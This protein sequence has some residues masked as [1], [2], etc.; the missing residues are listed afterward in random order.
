MSP[1][2]SSPRHLLPFSHAQSAV[3][4]IPGLLTFSACLVV[5]L[6]TL[7]PDLSWLYF[8]ADGGELITAAVTLGIPHPPG[9]PTYV[10]MGKLI[11]LLP[12]GAVAYRFNLLSAL[13]IAFAAGVTT[14]AAL[15]LVEDTHHG[16][17]AAIAAGLSFGFAPLVWSQALIAEVYG[18]NLAFLALFLWALLGKRP[19]LLTGIFLGLSMT[20]HLTSLLMLPLAFGL[21]PRTR[22]PRLISGI[23][24]G[25]TPFLLLPLFAKGNSPV[26][27]G[28]PNTLSGWW[29]LVSA[30]IYRPNLSIPGL[31]ELLTRLADWSMMAAQQF[32]WIGW[33]SVILAIF[34]AGHIENTRNKRQTP[35]ILGLLLGTAVLFA[36]LS[37]LYATEDAWLY[38]LPGILLTALVLARGLAQIGAWAF[39]LP[40]LLLLFNFSTFNTPKLPLA[41]QV[42]A[43]ALQP[44]PQNAIV[45]TP[46]DRSIFTLWYAQHIT[47]LRPDLT[48][49]DSNL[50]AFD[51]YR[52]RLQ[53]QYPTLQG[54]EIDD[55][56]QFQTANAQKRPFCRLSLLSPKTIL[57]TEDQP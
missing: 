4:G 5:Y 31:S 51:W 34:T 27:W 54:L 18:L 15:N 33:L 38:F 45:L 39:V 30:A 1:S 2:L 14:L 35:P 12:V 42:A 50:L 21:I 10:V 3:R 47:G 49:V 24:L 55:L 26:I 28:A 20:T 32:A 25:L 23:L 36:L 40:V 52:T 44:V 9:Y 11:S 46:G 37:L 13:S 19:S 48:L 53:H 6:L 41:N 16:R 7:A 8:G 29:W 22:W 43:E 57:C 17:F 56:E